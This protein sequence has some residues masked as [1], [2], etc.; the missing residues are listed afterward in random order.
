METYIP[1][2]RVVDWTNYAEAPK[3][4]NVS[5]WQN[6]WAYVCAHTPEEAYGIFEDIYLAGINCVPL[7][8]QG[9]SQQEIKLAVYAASVL[10]CTPEYPGLLLVSKED[11]LQAW[12]VQE[13]P[14]FLV[15]EWP[16]LPDI[17]ALFCPVA[18]KDIPRAIMRVLW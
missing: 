7:R 11:L 6:G 18:V 4:L 1:L 16:T 10:S 17:P 5:M 14:V 2:T 13:Y 3:D 8:T 9:L 15:G 12:A